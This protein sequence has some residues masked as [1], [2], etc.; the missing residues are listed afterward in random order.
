MEKRPDDITKP[1][2]EGPQ[3]ISN[4]ELMGIG[5]QNQ[6]IRSANLRIGFQDANPAVKIEGFERLDT[7]VSFFI[8]KD[9]KWCTV[10]QMI[11]CYRFR[12]GSPQ[13]LEIKHS[14]ETIYTY[15]AGDSMAGETENLAEILNGACLGQNDC[16]VAFTAVFNGLGGFELSNVPAIL[17]YAVTTTTLATTTTSPPKETTTL[18][19]Q[20]T[21]TLSHS[22]TTFDQTTTTVKGA[23][24]TIKGQ[25]TTT[26]VGGGGGQTKNNLAMILIILGGIVA[27][28][29]AYT[30][31]KK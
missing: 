18:P 6:A 12:C 4:L 9:P 28:I 31:R 7:K 8:G 20:T 22:G 5:E 2:P 19:T 29:L 25:I 10:N 3:P 27:V 17:E 16:R 15:K 30:R 23:T 1:A 24:T 21:T 13:S 11:K 14:S 26:T